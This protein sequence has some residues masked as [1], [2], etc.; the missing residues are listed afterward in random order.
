MLQ[1]EKETRGERG[2]G[3]QIGRR[4]KTE[5]IPEDRAR[6]EEGSVGGRKERR[7]EEGKKHLRRETG[8]LLYRGRQENKS[9]GRRGEQTSFELRTQL[10]VLL[11]SRNIPHL[12]MLKMWYQQAASSTS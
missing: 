1:E 11:F 5:M 3:R 2:K 12:M 8:K 9:S 10:L 7:T 6:R 4:E